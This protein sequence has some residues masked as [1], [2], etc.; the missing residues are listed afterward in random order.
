VSADFD[1]WRFLS[2]PDTAVDKARQKR[3]RSKKK[4]NKP[5]VIWSVSL[6][7]FLGLPGVIF[8]DIILGSLSWLAE[9]PL[10]FSWLITA[11]ALAMLV[12]LV[13]ILNGFGWARLAFAALALSQLAFDQTLVTRY[14]MIIF[15]IIGLLFVV[16]PSNLY[17]TDCTEARSRKKS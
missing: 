9:M 5:Q 8:S 10:W 4:T 15:A 7:F 11:H 2:S 16:R 6:G 3:A 14:F 1:I 12:C 13:F 17:F